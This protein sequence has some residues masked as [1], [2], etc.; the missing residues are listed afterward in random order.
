MCVCVVKSTVICVHVCV[1]VCAI[2]LT[3]ENTLSILDVV[4]ITLNT[5]S[6][7]KKVQ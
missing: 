6:I 1:C 7:S 5:F 4:L 2:G 3:R